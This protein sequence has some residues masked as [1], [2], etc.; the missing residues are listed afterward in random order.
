MKR[1]P[2]DRIYF[3]HATR[4]AHSRNLDP[5]QMAHILQKKLQPFIFFKIFKLIFSHSDLE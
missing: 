2:E 4:K 3:N 5:V 1:K